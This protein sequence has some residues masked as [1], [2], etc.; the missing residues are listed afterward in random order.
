[1]E[2]SNLVL[3]VSASTSSLHANRTCVYRCNRTW[4]VI[5]VANPSVGRGIRCVATSRGA[6]SP[7]PPRLLSPHRALL[8]IIFVARHHREEV[9]LVV[10]VPVTRTIRMLVARSSLAPAGAS[11]GLCRPSKCGTQSLEQGVPFLTFPKWS[12]HSKVLLL[13]VLAHS[14]LTAWPTL[15]AAG[16]CHGGFCQG[17]P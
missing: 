15:L 5:P 9:V 16:V 10:D 17:R 8:V 13:R 11:H 2:T 14:L 1:M 12:G 7:L 4:V 6:P 3:F